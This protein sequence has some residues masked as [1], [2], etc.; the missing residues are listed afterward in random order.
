M[1]VMA[2]IGE[3]PEIDIVESLGACQRL[4]LQ[5]GQIKG[6]KLESH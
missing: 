3:L 4:L 6:R 1:Q 2:T 5:T